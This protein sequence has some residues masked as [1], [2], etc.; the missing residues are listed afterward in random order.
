MNLE[1]SEFLV[2]LE[3]GAVPFEGTPI[4]AGAPQV[5]SARTY[6]VLGLNPREVE[7]LV[8][9]ITWVDGAREVFAPEREVGNHPR[10]DGIVGRHRLGI[11]QTGGLTYMVLA[12]SRLNGTP[13]AARAYPGLEDLQ[14]GAGVPFVDTLRS[15]GADAVDSREVL[16]GDSGRQRRRP[17]VTFHP[18]SAPHL[19]AV[20]FVLTRV[21]PIARGV[22]A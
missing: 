16:L 5:G 7:L 18:E 12:Q 19:P 17:I 4:G 6:R 10:F 20:V 15:F 11:Q 21:A 8:H 1:T 13:K 22:T 3:D 9:D 14:A 2:E